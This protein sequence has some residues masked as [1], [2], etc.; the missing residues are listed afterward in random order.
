MYHCKTLLRTRI[1]TAPDTRLESQ[2]NEYFEPGDEFQAD[3]ILVVEPRREEWALFTDPATGRQL[4]TAAYYP[5][6][7]TESKHFVDY[8]SSLPVEERI[9]SVRIDFVYEAGDLIALDVFETS[10]TG[11]VT[12][13]RFLKKAAC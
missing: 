13:S 5:R 2:T 8:S 10:S 9:A 12:N 11:S 6:N 1:R 4:Y 7:K 3:Q